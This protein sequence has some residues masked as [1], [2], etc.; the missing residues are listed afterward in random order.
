[1]TYAILLAIAGVTAVVYGLWLA[2]PPLGWVA[3]GTV[4]TLAGLYLEVGRGGER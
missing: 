4:I 1:M 2:W 3:A